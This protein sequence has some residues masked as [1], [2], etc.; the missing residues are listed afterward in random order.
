MA[1]SLSCPPTNFFP[2][3]PRHQQGIPCRRGGLASF[4]PLRENH[5]Q[6]HDSGDLGGKAGGAEFGRIEEQR[7]RIA[8]QTP[9]GVVFKAAA[10]LHGELIGQ[11]REIEKEKS[12]ADD[13]LDNAQIPTVALKIKLLE[14]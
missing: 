8:G 6:R 12:R 4:A 5:Y 14:R 2:T 13:R 3:S 10:R 7:H 11:R 1:S 9:A